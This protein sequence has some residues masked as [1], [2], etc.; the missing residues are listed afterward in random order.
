ME[1]FGIVSIGVKEKPSILL[2]KPVS[3]KRFKGLE[4]EI[5][6][7]PLMKDLF[8]LFFYNTDSVK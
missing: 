4:V 7:C 1:G 8:K 2:D 6:L 3:T 5:L